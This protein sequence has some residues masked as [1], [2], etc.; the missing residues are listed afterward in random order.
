MGGCNQSPNRVSDPLEIQNCLLFSVAVER[1]L[2][3][4]WEF[5]EKLA[6]DIKEKKKKKTVR[7]AILGNFREL[8]TR[9]RRRPESLIEF[10]FL[11]SDNND[12][13]TAICIARRCL[14]NKLL[15]SILAHY[16]TLRF[17][18]Q[19]SLS[20]SHKITSRVYRTAN[21]GTAG[22]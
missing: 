11:I 7:F 20:F 3:A 14:G 19:A 1:N 17:T 18:M 5:D 15:Q 8:F 12:G 4:L 22:V 9:Q 10:I 2:G 6:V 13:V 16:L 21:F